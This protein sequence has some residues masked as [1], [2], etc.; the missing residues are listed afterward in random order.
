L[1]YRRWEAKGSE[2][3]ITNIIPSLLYS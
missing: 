1:L 3:M 2:L